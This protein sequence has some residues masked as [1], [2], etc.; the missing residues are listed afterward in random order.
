MLE[1]GRCLACTA[2][3]VVYYNAPLRKSL[4]IQQRD[5]VIRARHAEGEAQADLAREFGISYQRVYQ[6]IRGRSH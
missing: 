4:T 1:D 3:A 2:L 5:N 6:I